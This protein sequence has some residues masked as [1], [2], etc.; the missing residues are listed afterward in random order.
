MQFGADLP[1]AVED[2]SEICVVEE[3]VFGISWEREAF[4]FRVRTKLLVDAPAS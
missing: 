3:G 2:M 1:V 4:W